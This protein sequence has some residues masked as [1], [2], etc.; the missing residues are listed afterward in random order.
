MK[1]IIL[2]ILS[3]FLLT[4][5]NT[6]NKVNNLNINFDIEENEIELNYDT[7]NPLVAMQIENYGA[8]VIELYP[9]YAPNTVNNFISLVQSGFYDNN[10][11]AYFDYV[12]NEDC[13]KELA[14]QL[15]QEI[16]ILEGDNKHNRGKCPVIQYDLKGN[17]IAEYTSYMDAQR[18][19]GIRSGNIS[20]CCRGKRHTAGSFIWRDLIESSTTIENVISE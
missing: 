10:N 6:N 11:L 19:T 17:K 13:A 16:K 2:I 1:K 12:K 7:D 18:K 3:I 5:C 20:L 15:I 9:E 14:E 4:S 8:I